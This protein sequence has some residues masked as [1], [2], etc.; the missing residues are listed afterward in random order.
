VVRVYLEDLLEIRKGIVVRVSCK[1]L[2]FLDLIHKGA[3]AV[4]ISY[5]NARLVCQSVRNDHVVNFF[6]QQLFSIIYV[7]LVLLG[8]KL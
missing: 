4:A 7:G 8:Q 5:N 2:S 6:E 3:V 1:H